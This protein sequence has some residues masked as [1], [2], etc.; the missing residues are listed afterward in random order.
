MAKALVSTGQFE[1]LFQS[2]YNN[3]ASTSSALFD[4]A[5]Y[6]KVMSEFSD[7]KELVF[8]SLLAKG[9]FDDITTQFPSNR[10]QRNL[11]F[12]RGKYHEALM[13]ENNSRY[14]TLQA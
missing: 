14:R 4:S 13:I 8:H 11:L 3:R 10:S 7:A 6:D 5:N 1:K 2:N 9:Q 12:E